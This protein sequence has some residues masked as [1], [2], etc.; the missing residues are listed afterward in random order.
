MEESDTP[1]WWKIESVSMARHFNVLRVASTIWYL[2]HGLCYYN[3]LKIRALTG[4]IDRIIE[5]IVAQLT[6]MGIDVITLNT[7]TDQAAD[8]YIKLQLRKLPRNVFP[9]KRLVLL[10]FDEGYSDLLEELKRDGYNTVVRFIPGSVGSNLMYCSK[11]IFSSYLSFITLRLL[12]KKL[13]MQ[14]TCV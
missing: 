10:T 11:F 14:Q 3:R 5:K 4:H 12:L 7:D 6:F 9:R 1:V 13:E 8:S 2:M